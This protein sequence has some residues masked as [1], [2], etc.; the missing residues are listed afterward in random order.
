MTYE[1]AMAV[2]EKN[3][4]LIGTTTEKN[5]VI[6]DIAIVP[7]DEAN[8]NSFFR[9]YVITRDWR[10]GILP[11]INGDMRVWAIDTYHLIKNNVLFFNDITDENLTTK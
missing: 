5:F 1:E 7:S 9:Y 11:Y 4:N 8:R 3:K 6:G 2:V 10:R